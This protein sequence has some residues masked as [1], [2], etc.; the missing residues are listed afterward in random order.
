MLMTQS[1]YEH[2]KFLGLCKVCLNES[3]FRLKITNFTHMQAVK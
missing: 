1:L 2:L 3:L